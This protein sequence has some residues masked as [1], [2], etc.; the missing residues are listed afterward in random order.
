MIV[1]CFNKYIKVCNLC[2]G[3]ITYKFKK[4]LILDYYMIDFSEFDLT[5]NEGKVYETLVK[6]GKLSAS[7]VSSKSGV[8]YGRVYDVLESLVNK[9]LVE[10]VPEKTKKFVP[11]DPVFLINFIKEK[12]KRLQKAKE[13]VKDLKKFYEIKEKNPIIIGE[14]KKAF[15]KIADE[16][17]IPQKY[18]Y[19]IK[20]TSEFRPS[21]VERVRKNKKRGVDIRVLTRYDDET[22]KDVK[23]WLRIN[24]NI[25]KID[26][27]GFVFSILDDEEV[28]LG[29]IKNNMTFLI[30]DKS[31]ANVMKKLFLAYYKDAEKID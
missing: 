7:E 4:E 29:L 12:E 2:G 19:A 6:F 9:G 30:K 18:D 23:K 25:R 20:W 11:A 1:N 31:F 21:S 27:G 15:W 28:L 26:N 14:G 5:K 13:Q 10:I 17:K 8:P 24:P 16:M 22:K 3:C